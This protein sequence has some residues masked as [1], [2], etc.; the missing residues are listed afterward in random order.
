MS[1]SP[2]TTSTASAAAA[3]VPV[4]SRP[5]VDPDLGDHG[6]HRRDP[7]PDE[8]AEAGPGQAGA[9]GVEPPREQHQRERDEPADEHAGQA[10]QQLRRGCAGGS[11]CQR[12]PRLA[13]PVRR[14][15]PRG[16]AGGR[17]TTRSAARAGRGKR[18]PGR[19]PRPAPRPRVGQRPPRRPRRAPGAP[20]SDASSCTAAATSPVG[21]WCSS[22]RRQG[23]AACARAAS[24]VER[25]RRGAAGVVGGRDAGRSCSRRRRARRPRR[26]IRSTRPSA[27][28]RGVDTDTHR[29]SATAS[30]RPRAPA[31]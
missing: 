27:T 17:R 13:S 19:R 8:H 29:S 30:P 3:S 15:G 21:R 18:R 4:R 24:G 10:A 25:Q 14:H 7:V 16:S 31:T 2:P 22:T 23:G 1:V 6:G 11:R 26:S 20:R 9:V 28:I 5:A 12:R